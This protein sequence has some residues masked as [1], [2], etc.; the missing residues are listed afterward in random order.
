MTIYQHSHKISAYGKLSYKDW[1]RCDAE[2]PD[3]KLFCGFGVK[4]DINSTTIDS[5]SFDINCSGNIIPLLEE[6]NTTK[7]YL[8]CQIRRGNDI[9]VSA[10]IKSLPS[11]IIKFDY[12]NYYYDNNNFIINGNI[13]FNWSDCLHSSGL[14]DFKCNHFDKIPTENSDF[15]N[16]IEVDCK[17]TSISYSGN[18]PYYACL[19]NDSYTLYDL[20]YIEFPSIFYL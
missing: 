5:Q 1:H 13:H 9:I 6:S 8:I 14:V 3:L 11:P 20:K 15:G 19:L 2:A 7:N 17:N 18:D 10:E 12:L 16:P 4:G